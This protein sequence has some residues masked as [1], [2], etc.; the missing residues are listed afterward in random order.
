[1]ASTKTNL[2][3]DS[4]NVVLFRDAFGTT[5]TTRGTTYTWIQ[6]GNIIE[7][8]M[9]FWDR[10]VTFIPA[11]DPCSGQIVLENTA[12]HEFGHALGLDHSTRTAASMYATDSACSEAC[13]TLHADDITGVETLYPCG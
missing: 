2:A 6:S 5:T 13:L 1:G 9:I 4:E 3:F 7:A 12:I 11:G 10:A 8:D